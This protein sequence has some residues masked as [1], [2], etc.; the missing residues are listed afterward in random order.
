MRRFLFSGTFC[1]LNK[2][3][4]AMQLSA[5]RSLQAVMPE[6]EIT[7]LSSFPDIDRPTYAGYKLCKSSRRQPFA[8]LMC[9]VRAGLWRVVKRY[10]RVDL[11]F[12]LAGAELQAYRDADVLV[13]L[14]GDTLTEDYGIKCVMSHLMPIFTA[15]CLQRPVVLYAQTIGPFGVT[16]PLAK[17]ALKRVTLITARE[18][19]SF[20][21]V[22]S[23][24]I[25]EPSLH[26]TADVA[27][28]LDPAEPERVDTI[29]AA[30][31]VS[32]ADAPL[33]G[34]T[35]SRL[36]GHR[37]RPDDPHQFE[38]L[39]ATVADYLIESK[40]A[41]VVL[42][43]HVLGLGEKRDDRIMAGRVY[44]KIK[45]K[46]KTRL[47]AGDYRPEELKGVIGRFQLFLGLRM[48]A[49]I[50]A[51]AMGVPTLAIAYS[52]KTLGIM[53]MFGQ[54]RWVCDITTL[55][56]GELTTTMEALWSQREGVRRDLRARLA[57]VEQRARENA[58][59]VKGVVD[60]LGLTQGSLPGATKGM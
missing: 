16:R 58:V 1:A 53:R 43:S 17:F 24:G 27:F 14:S 59:L 42:L 37:F 2:G 57:A 56:L 39:I 28:L 6:A 41:T 49:N 46:A 3:D 20:D 36:L 11:R 48:H 12:L 38:T 26:L 25:A 44:E 5:Y 19:L 40:G 32:E 18:E 55:T 4:A 13:D 15:L 34:I 31:G 35:V 21:Y 60:T 52:R 33:V 10:A 30:E 45:H 47:L 8:A 7:I 22:R 23:M 29:L 9:L 50:A 54:E 51:L